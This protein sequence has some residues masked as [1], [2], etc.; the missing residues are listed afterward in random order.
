M[1]SACGWLKEYGSSFFVV[2]TTVPHDA[3]SLPVLSNLSTR[4]VE[5]PCPDECPSATKMSPL[6]ATRRLFGWK[7]NSG[8]RPPPGLPSVRRSL[9]SGLNLKTWCPLVGLI[10]GVAADA[11]A[12][13]PRRPPPIVQAQST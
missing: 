7:K 10:G 4:A 9:P 8:S 11:P 12:A 5:L 6:G 13:P 2:S 1:A 3:S